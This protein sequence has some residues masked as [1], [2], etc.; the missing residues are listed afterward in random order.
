[1]PAETITDAP[2]RKPRAANTE[3]RRA[4]LLAATRASIVAN[5]LQ[6][7]TLATVAKEAG[8]S[9]GVA[10]FYFKSKTGLLTEVL[11]DHYA[12]YE[13][14]W[15]EYLDAAGEDPL[16]RLVALTE[17]DF[18]PAVCGPEPLSIWFAFWGELRSTPQYAEVAEGFD[19]GRRRELR[20]LCAQLSPEEE[21][22]D[23]AD[24]LDRLSDGYWQTLHVN[25]AGLSPEA[26]RTACLRL[27]ARL[28]PQHAGRIA[29]RT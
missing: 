15:R 28:L 20:A 26:G 9:Q 3:R 22:D 5:G 14:N 13:R 17:A 12:R 16:D 29:R 25:P 19:R 6:R 7:T 27:I 4:Q 21:S 11:R 24:W 2:P 18:D 8:L 23:M 1:M 10:V